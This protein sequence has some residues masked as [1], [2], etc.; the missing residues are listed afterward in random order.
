MAALSTAHATAM[1]AQ[2]AD[3][4]SALEDAL[5]VKKATILDSG[6]NVCIISDIT[7]LDTNTVPLCRRAEDAAGVETASGVAMPIS[8]RGLLVGL[9][10][11]LCLDA[12]T[13]LLSV[14]QLCKEREAIVI[15]DA[16]GA[17]AVESDAFN[18]SHVNCIKKHSITHSKPL[19]TA[20]L[21]SAVEC[22][23][24]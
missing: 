3:F 9:E 11:P 13:T 5:N 22:V 7:H 20:T 8:G 17:I 4:E 14:P 21:T 10:G 18:K 24:H 16:V 19:L 23:L 1:A 15:M 2:K 6:A 12:T